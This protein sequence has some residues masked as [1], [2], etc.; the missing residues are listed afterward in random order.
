MIFKT[1]QSQL[2]P[3]TKL[4]HSLPTTPYL[5]ETTV[6][7]GRIAN[8]IIKI[9]NIWPARFNPT[10]C[11]SYYWQKP[12]SLRLP[13][14]AVSAGDDTQMKS[15]VT[16]CFNRAAL[17][18]FLVTK[19]R[20]STI[21]LKK[22]SPKKLLLLEK[23]KGLFVQ[24]LQMVNLINSS[25]FTDC[26]HLASLAVCIWVVAFLVTKWYRFLNL[27]FNYS[28]PK[29]KYVPADEGQNNTLLDWTRIWNFLFKLNKWISYL[30]YNL[31]LLDIFQ[32]V[33]NRLAILARNMTT[34]AHPET[35][36]P[37]SHRSNNNKMEIKISNCRPRT[38]NARRGDRR[39]NSNL[40]FSD[41]DGRR[42]EI[43]RDFQV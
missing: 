31:S 42:P 13:R 27:G 15:S 19:R 16:G 23:A 8:I 3:K 21:Q 17:P 22:F 18:L 25:L 7:P 29:R 38:V 12:G 28:I 6:L 34:T 20:G 43:W 41:N 40:D 1:E 10:V 14:R 30:S 24:P 33:W 11:L 5:M 32:P 35:A 39:G 9:T 4:L 2:V 37:G 36:H 26:V